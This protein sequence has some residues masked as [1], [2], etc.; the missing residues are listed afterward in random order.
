MSP[1]TYWCDVCRTAYPI[2]RERPEVVRARHRADFHGGGVPQGERFDGVDGPR[3]INS[4]QVLIALGVLAVF[5]LVSS[6][7]G[8][9][10]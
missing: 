6:L 8:I 2:G 7:L 4:R 5:A 3:E 9:K 1:A 10:L